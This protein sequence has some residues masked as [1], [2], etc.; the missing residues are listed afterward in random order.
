MG[1]SVCGA[2]RFFAVAEIAKGSANAAS[3][4]PKER[5]TVVSWQREG[6]KGARSGIGSDV[7]RVWGLIEG[8]RDRGQPS[9][10]QWLEVCVPGTA[11]RD[12]V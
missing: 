10:M 8:F 12:P 2:I 5:G 7:G 9:C 6:R 1:T 4:E 11:H 3:R